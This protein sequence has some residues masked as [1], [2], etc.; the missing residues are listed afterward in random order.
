MKKHAIAVLLCVLALN[1]LGGFTVGGSGLREY[2][3][4]L[5]HIS[6]REIP[7]LRANPDAR[8]LLLERV[9]PAAAEHHLAQGAAPPAQGRAGRPARHI[10]NL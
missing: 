8:Q 2:Y 4:S 9:D 7:P 10:K 1:V 5:I 6:Q 3:L